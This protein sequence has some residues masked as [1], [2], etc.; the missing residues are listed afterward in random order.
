MYKLVIKISSQHPRDTHSAINLNLIN[1]GNWKINK[2]H[3]Q[4][5][6]RE[7]RVCGIRVKIEKMK[8]EQN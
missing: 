8:L 4:Q 6:I 2:L 7:V 1:G 3:T 5:C